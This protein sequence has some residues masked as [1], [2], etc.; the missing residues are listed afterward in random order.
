MDRKKQCQRGYKM[1]SN[2]TCVPIR[3]DRHRGALTSLGNGNNRMAMG[4]RVSTRR[5][6]VPKP[7]ALM[8]RGKQNPGAAPT[9]DCLA[10]CQQAYGFGPGMDSCTSGIEPGITSC[11]CS[12][13]N[14]T[15]ITQ[16]HYGWYP[17]EMFQDGAATQCNCSPCYFGYNDCIRSCSDNNPDNDMSMPEKQFRMGGRIK[18]G[19]R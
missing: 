6:Q 10:M 16:Q 11:E 15:V 7:S 3:K 18:R 5:N 1:S 12:C 19:R 4:G 2:G 8:R 17:W 9:L 14:H 13:C